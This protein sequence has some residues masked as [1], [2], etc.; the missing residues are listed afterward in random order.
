M[1]AEFKMESETA[2]MFGCPVCGFRVS[3]RDSACPRCGNEF[4]IATKFECPF[5]GELVEPG[6]KTCPSCHVNYSDFKEKTEARGGDDSIDE[7]LMEIIKMESQAVKS[8][9]KRLSCPICSWMLDGTESKCPKCG[10]SFVEDVT[11]QC[12]VCG[13]LVNA[14]AVRCSEC[15]STFEEEEAGEVAAA[16]AHTDSA[17]DEIMSAASSVPSYESRPS[18]TPKPAPEPERSQSAKSK[19]SAMFGRLTDAVREEPKKPA[20]KPEPVEIERPEPEPEPAPV[21]KEEQIS[22]PE[23]APPV[24]EEQKPEPEQAPRE[25]EPKAD[26]SDQPKKSRQRKLKTKTKKG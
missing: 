5:C 10:K 25:E 6:M 14:N 20:P 22:E 17:L 13:S 16:H 15:G 1:G 7:I 18:E 24:V 23:V 11:F 21:P 4:N 12:P 26:E 8:E 19:V 2:K 3:P 9:E